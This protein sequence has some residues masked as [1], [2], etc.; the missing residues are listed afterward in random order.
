MEALQ[1]LGSGIMAAFEEAPSNAGRAKAVFMPTVPTFAVRET[2]VSRHNGVTSG[3]PLQP[4]RDD[5]AL[6]ALSSLRDLRGAPDVSLSDS[7]CWNGGQKVALF[8]SIERFAICQVSTILFYRA[9]R[10]VPSLHLCV[11]PFML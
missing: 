6:I 5:S 11:S 1:K 7:K 3:A 4:L 9:F 2:N 8:C 10:D